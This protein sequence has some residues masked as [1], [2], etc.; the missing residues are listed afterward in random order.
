MFT[1]LLMAFV[2]LLVC[3]YL[4]KDSNAA[5]REIVDDK[6]LVITDDDII[7]DLNVPTEPVENKVN[8]VVEN[9]I[10]DAVTTKKGKPGRKKKLS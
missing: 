7:Q 5:L 2:V 9:Q 4:I 1:F 6:K 8:T 3:W 10:T